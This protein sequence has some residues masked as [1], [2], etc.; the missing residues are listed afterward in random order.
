MSEHILAV[1]YFF[2][3]NCT[4]YCLVTFAAGDTAPE[5]VSDCTY[6]T[7]STYELIQAFDNIP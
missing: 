7:T 2:Q 1:V 3:Y 4:L 5:M 6:P